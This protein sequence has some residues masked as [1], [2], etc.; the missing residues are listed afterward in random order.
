MVESQQLRLGRLTVVSSLLLLLIGQGCSSVGSYQ[1]G[2]IA[3]KFMRGDIFKRCTEY[4]GPSRNPVIVIHGFLG[5]KLRRRTD[6]RQVWGSFGTLDIVLGLD[7]QQIRDLGYP[8]AIGSSLTATD[9]EVEPYAFLEMV[10]V[11]LFGMPF[12]VNAYEDLLK[13][14]RDSGYVQYGKPLPPGKHFYSLFP[15]YYDWRR[16]LPYNAARLHAYIQ[17]Q[18]AYLQ[19]EYEKLYGIKNYDVQFDVI[20][21]SMGGLLSRYYL[22]YGDADLPADGS[23]PELT[24]KGSKVIDKLLIIGTPNAGYLDTCLEMINGL[25]VAPGTPTYPPAML[26]TFA[27]YYQMMPVY[28]FRTVL[29]EDDPYGAEVDI[30]DPEVWIKMQWGLAD[31]KQDQVLQILLPEIKDPAQ[32][33]AIALDHLRKCLRRARQFTAAMQIKARPPENVALFLFAGDAIETSRTAVVNRKTGKIKVVEYA[34]GDGKILTSSARFDLR[35]DGYWTPFLRSPITWHG[36]FLLPAAHM[37]ITRAPSFA[38]NASFCLLVT[39][40]VKQDKRDKRTLDGHQKLPLNIE[41][42]GDGVFDEKKP[43]PATSK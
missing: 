8:M 21:H 20:A 42:L 33:R 37:G 2:E 7:R 32:R 4:E 41:Y 15:F 5:S 18:R 6:N 3:E 11:Q 39:P 43:T 40:S 27:T 10:Q 9:S 29:Y 34:P 36:T 16:D 24:W 30:F 35:E 12:Y 38:S 17:T 13:I 14:L 22:R 28:G 23:L 25:Q 19:K 1:S 26:G 31:P